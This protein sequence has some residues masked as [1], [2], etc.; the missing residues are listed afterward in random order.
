MRVKNLFFI[1]K[2]IKPKKNNVKL[3]VQKKINKENNNTQD[4][5]EI[6]S[7]K[8]DFIEQQ[9]FDKTDN[10]ILKNIF[11]ILKHDKNILIY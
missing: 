5:S 1:N 9:S 11:N 7:D 3:Q 6:K 4:S 8:E 2:N 10:I